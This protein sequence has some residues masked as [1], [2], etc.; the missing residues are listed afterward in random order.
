MDERVYPSSSNVRA[1]GIIPPNINSE[2]IN[3]TPSA[4]FI[5]SHIFLIFALYVPISLLLKI[6]F[7][8]PLIY[9]RLYPKF[10]ISLELYVIADFNPFPP[11]K[12]FLR[13]VDLLPSVISGYTI[14]SACIL[15]SKAL[16]P[17][18][19]PSISS[20]GSA[21]LSSNSETSGSFVSFII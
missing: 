8:L 11:T 16:H 7:P 17:N 20:S 13:V 18:P 12:Y 15:P 5:H 4:F 1:I 6:P 2:Y 3:T 21:S 10:V 9:S 19:T 14:V